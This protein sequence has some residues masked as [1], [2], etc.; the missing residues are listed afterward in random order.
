MPPLRRDRQVPRR[1]VTS[2]QMPRKAL[3]YNPRN[4]HCP[5]EA[6]AIVSAAQSG[7]KRGMQSLI[8]ALQPEVKRIAT[9]Y[10]Q[11]TAYDDAGDYM[12]EAW[13]A[14]FERLPKVDVTCGNAIAHLVVYGR[15]AIQ[16][17]TKRHGNHKKREPF[18]EDLKVRSYASHGDAV[19]AMLAR[20]AVRRVAAEKLNEKQRSIV[21]H[22]MDGLNGEALEQATGLSK[23]LISYHMKTIRR[24]YQEELG[25]AWI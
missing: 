22:K 3:K 20:E 17:A 2:S 13:L 6:A 25:G 9:W 8:D 23:A 4:S 21:K 10:A 18:A 16:S 14:I 19:P 12:S 5:A 15:Y 24:V 11:F 7:S 1:S